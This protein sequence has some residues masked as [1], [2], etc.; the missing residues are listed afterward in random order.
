LPFPALDGG[1]IFFLLIEKL[2][3]RAFKQQWEN[4]AHNLGFALLM[5]LVV[6]V[7]YRDIVRYGGKAWSGLLQM[8]GL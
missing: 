1:R 7:T 5:L 2:R 4:L 3:G 8:F 6:I